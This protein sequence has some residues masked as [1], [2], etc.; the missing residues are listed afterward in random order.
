MTNTESYKFF[1]INNAIKNQAF[2]ALKTA[3]NAY[4]PLSDSTWNTF[5]KFCEC[6]NVNKN[7]ALYPSGQVPQSFA[8]VYQGLFRAFHIDDKGHEYNKTFFYEGCFPGSMTALLTN[9]ATATTIDALESSIIITINFK[10]Y[11][12]LLLTSE[13]LKLFQIYYLEKNWLLTKD[14][15]ENEIIQEDATQRY[16]R[17]LQEFPELNQRLAQYHIASHLGI[18]PTQLS[19]IRKNNKT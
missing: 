18:T 12:Q 17:F 2:L 7:E 11:R 13:D 3:M 15:R 8:F 10:Q 19:R 1:M 16:Q 14:A 9:S 4:Y 5:I 6:I